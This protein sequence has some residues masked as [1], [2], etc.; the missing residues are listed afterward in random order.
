MAI[1]FETASSGCV[2]EVKARNEFLS[3]PF[4]QKRADL[5]ELVAS[6]AADGRRAVVRRDS[7][8]THANNLR[9]RLF[10]PAP[11]SCICELGFSGVA[12][13]RGKR[14]QARR[15]N[16]FAGLVLFLLIFS[17]TAANLKCS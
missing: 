16:T 7:E 10:S 8:A 15:S 4:F 9:A 11:E 5:D 17:F 6:V 14:I 1:F 13:S 12:G 3:D 2:N